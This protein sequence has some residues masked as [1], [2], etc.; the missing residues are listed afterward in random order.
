MFFVVSI[1]G[2]PGQYEGAA[3]R[4][5]TTL[6]VPCHKKP[7]AAS[8]GDARFRFKDPFCA[9]TVRKQPGK[10]MP[11]VFLSGTG[12]KTYGNHESLIQVHR[13][14]FLRSN[15]KKKLS[16]IPEAIK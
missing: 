13:R 14:G 2:S 3:A 12:K 15:R 9:G 4:R 7:G 8:K 5:K 16:D 1:F 10:E 11:V 6:R